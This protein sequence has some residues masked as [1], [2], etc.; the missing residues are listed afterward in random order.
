[1]TVR[2]AAEGEQQARERV[3]DTHL[4]R[5]LK[6]PARTPPSLLLSKRKAR[7][8]ASGKAGAAWDFNNF[9]RPRQL[10]LGGRGLWENCA[11]L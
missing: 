2:R 8:G 4:P 11:A 5:D 1:V 6:C 10:R 9:F 7:A 3:P